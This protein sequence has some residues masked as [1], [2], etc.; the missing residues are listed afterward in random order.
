MTSLEDL[1]RIVISD[2]VSAASECERLRIAG[3]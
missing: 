2:G 1:L 3:L